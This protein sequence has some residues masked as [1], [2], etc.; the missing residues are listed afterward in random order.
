[1]SQVQF[2]VSLAP[3]TED[4]DTILKL[5]VTADAAGL[6]LLAIQDHPYV[7][8]F[9]DTFSLIGHLL[10]RTTQ[11]RIFPDVANLPLR[12]PAMLAKAAAT[13]DLLSGGRFEL[14]LGGGASMDAIAAM[15]GPV[16]A[17][18]DALPALAEAI[19]VIRALWRAGETAHAG[20]EHHRVEGVDA[21]P[22][23]AHAIGIWLG[24]MGPRALDLTG[25]VADGWAAPIPKYLAHE[26]RAQAQDRIDTA[27]RA[28]GRDPRSIRRLAQLPGIITDD[29]DDGAPVGNDSVIGPPQRWVETIDHFVRDLRY[30]TV[31]FWPDQT[32]EIQLR[33]FTDE[34][35]P[36]VAK[37]PPDTA[38]A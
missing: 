21:G 29:R 26:D 10:S 2:G 30:D 23:P 6:D 1:M 9:V 19:D 31:I 20:G 28:A 4:L 16:L 5:A 12:P 17:R 27:A 11:I 32:N 34:V 25:R 14:G 3:R 13:L 8:E 38:R 33:R 18:R 7:A 15:G 36:G 22:A 35:V 24:S 37:Q